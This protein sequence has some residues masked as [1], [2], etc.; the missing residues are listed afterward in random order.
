MNLERMQHVL[1][2]ANL[3][4]WLFYDF[5]KSNP[6]AYAVLQLPTE[7][8]YTRRWFTMSLPRERQ[9]PLSVLLSHMY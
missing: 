6:I 1:Q 4:G 5:R 7:A 2:D 9:Q 3:N 8:M